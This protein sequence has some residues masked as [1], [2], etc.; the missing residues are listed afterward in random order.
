M[1]DV[2]EFGEVAEVDEVAEVADVGVAKK[3]YSPPSPFIYG[4]EKRV[5][6]SVY[7]LTNYE[8]FQTRSPFFFRTASYEAFTKN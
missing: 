7:I 2:L 8:K 6:P 1:N 5:W 4:L 3:F